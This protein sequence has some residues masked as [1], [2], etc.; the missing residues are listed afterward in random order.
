V[1][2]TTYLNESDE[3]E[4]VNSNVTFDFKTTVSVQD[5]KFGAE[6]NRSI[7]IYIYDFDTPLVIRVS[8]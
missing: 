7:R 2:I 6:T 4:V 5:Y 8:I 3:E 1:N